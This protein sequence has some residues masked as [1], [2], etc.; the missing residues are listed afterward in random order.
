MGGWI[1]EALS[2]ANR[3]HAGINV[4]VVTR[5]KERA[6]RTFQNSNFFGIQF[7][8]WDENLILTPEFLDRNI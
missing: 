2:A 3:N 1:L 7:L 8:Q 5:D 4:K 6:E